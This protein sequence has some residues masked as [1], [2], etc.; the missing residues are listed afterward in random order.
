M[1]NIKIKSTE[2]LF[3]SV[4]SE[5]QYIYNDLYLYNYLLIDVKIN[6][7]TCKK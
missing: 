1:N 4:D 2:I 6:F 3:L 5:F 7:N